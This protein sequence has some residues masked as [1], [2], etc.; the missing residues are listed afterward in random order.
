MLGEGSSPLR[1]AVSAPKRAS[2]VA[3]RL[4]QDGRSCKPDS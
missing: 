4:H 2:E 1:P 3:G